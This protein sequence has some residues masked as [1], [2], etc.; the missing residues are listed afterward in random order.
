VAAH[1]NAEVLTQYQ[2]LKGD[3]RVIPLMDRYFRYQ[4]RALPTRPLRDWGKF[5]WQDELLSVLWLYNRTGSA[6]LIDLA[7][8]LKQQGHDWQAQYADFQYKQRITA[9]YIKLEEGGGLKDLALSTHGVNNGQA[10]KA[11][12][13]WSM[14][15]G[16]PQDRAA[17]LKMIAELDKYHG[18]PNGM[19]SCDE[20]LAGTDPSQ[21]S[22][23][24]T[25]VEYMFSLEQSL[26]ITG[27][28]SLGDKLERLAFNALRGRSQTTCG[29]TNTTRSP[30]RLNAACT[31]SRGRRMDRNRIS[32]DWS[33]TSGVARPTSIRGGRNLPTVFSSCPARTGALRK[34]AWLLRCTLRARSQH[35]FAIR[36]SR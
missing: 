21:G 25:V 24:C 26:A 23:L 13:V 29:R 32:M 14:V 22:E 5:R 15:S 30:T 3:P 19:F 16:Q 11:G 8:L 35:P 27:D 6:Y 10:V 1:R 2:E 4:L 34:M 17:V 18:L 28:A 7:K 36:R 20:H 12:P 9:E 33:P 31:T